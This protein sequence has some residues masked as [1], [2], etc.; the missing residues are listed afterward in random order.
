MT[1][2]PQ[3]R[4]YAPPIFAGDIVRSSVYGQVV[5]TKAKSVKEGDKMVVSGQW[6]EYVKVEEGPFNVPAL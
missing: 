5:A 3:K 6:A 2:T 1:L 4:M